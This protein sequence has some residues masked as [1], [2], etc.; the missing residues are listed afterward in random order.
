MKKNWVVKH[1]LEDWVCFWMFSAVNTWLRC[2]KRTAEIWVSLVDWE[3]NRLLGASACGKVRDQI[4]LFGWRYLCATLVKKRRHQEMWEGVYNFI[5]LCETCGTQQTAVCDSPFMRE[6]IPFPKKANVL[7]AKRLSNEISFSN[8]IFYRKRTQK[9]YVHLA[10]ITDEFS[11]YE[12]TACLK[13][14]RKL[15]F[16]FAVEEVRTFIL[17]SWGKKARYFKPT[18]VSINKETIPCYFSGEL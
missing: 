9:S 12:R 10:E 2:N 13:I 5:E 18:L 6:V 17:L 16:L 4:K 14:L 15:F 7:W 3:K 1:G 8:D 11:F